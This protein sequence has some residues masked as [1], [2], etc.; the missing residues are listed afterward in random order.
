MRLLAGCIT[1][2]G[3]LLAVAAI[4]IARI[5]LYDSLGTYQGVGNIG[6]G[7]VYLLTL[8]IGLIVLAW[9]VRRRRPR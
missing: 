6:S 2:A 8:A 9:V 4:C 5:R 7:P 3:T 1:I